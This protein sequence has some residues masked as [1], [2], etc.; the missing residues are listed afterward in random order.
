MALQCGQGQETNPPSTFLFDALC[1]PEQ[2]WELHLEEDE[3][4]EE[5]C[6]YSD[7]FGDPPFTVLEQDLFWDDEEL[8]SLSSKESPNPLHESLRAKP[9]LLGA[10]AEAVEWIL[11]AQAH[12]GFSV[13]TAVLAVNCLDRFLS[14]LR[15]DTDKPWMSQL[16][17]VAC[18]SLAAK[19]EETQVPLLLDIQVR[20]NFHWQKMIFFFFLH[21]QVKIL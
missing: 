5:E 7:D 8:I 12:H 20:S 18:L 2:Q 15:L 6:R 4:L 11:E 13:P 14:S 17:A 21:Y 10:R 16:A 19:V 9:A 3:G 1:C